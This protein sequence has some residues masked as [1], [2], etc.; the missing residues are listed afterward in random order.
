MNN[1]QP[2]CIILEDEP[3]MRDLLVSQLLRTGLLKIIGSFE[4][5]ISATLSVE[6]LK[7]DLLFLDVNIKGMDGPYFMEALNY[8]PKIIVISGYTEDVMKNF[9]LVY[10]LFIRKPVTTAVLTQAIRQILD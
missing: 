8:K 5:T 4:D 3:E 7:P 9:E 2:T 10:D 6:R 1:T